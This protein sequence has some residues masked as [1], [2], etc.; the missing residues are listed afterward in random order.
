MRTGFAPLLFCRS[1]QPAG[2]GMP[3]ASSQGVFGKVRR[4]SACCR[5]NPRGGAVVQIKGSPCKRGC[6]IEFHLQRS[7]TSLC[8]LGCS[9]S[10]GQ[11]FVLV[12]RP[13]EVPVVVHLGSSILNGGGKKRSSEIE[14]ISPGVLL[15]MRALSRSGR[16]SGNTL[17]GA[18]KNGE[19][20]L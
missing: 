13:T 8:V 5:G 4:A 6:C 17:T 16:E 19:E 11:L 7:F 9:C 12:Q 2:T 20:K 18:P 1:T 15:P 14:P 10:D 3:S